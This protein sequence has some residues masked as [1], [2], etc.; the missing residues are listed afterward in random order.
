MI[1]IFVPKDKKEDDVGTDILTFTVPNKIIAND[2]PGMEPLEKERR[3]R[4]LL[5]EVYLIGF[6]SR[7]QLEQR[8]RRDREIS[9]S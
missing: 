3:R 2:R 4:K 9:N 5:S 6:Y 7:E 1:T 8:Q